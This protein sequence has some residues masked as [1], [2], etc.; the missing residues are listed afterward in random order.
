M[1]YGIWIWQPER[2]GKSKRFMSVV[3]KMVAANRLGVALL[4]SACL[5]RDHSYLF[6]FP[7]ARFVIDE[8][9]CVSMQGHDYRSFF[10]CLYEWHAVA[11]P[12]LCFF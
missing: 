5:A 4:P 1:R 3:K 9:H 8:A 11:D 12:I 7:A 2:I 6:L 10:P